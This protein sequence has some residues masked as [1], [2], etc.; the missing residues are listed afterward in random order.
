VLQQQQQQQQRTHV[1]GSAGPQYCGPPPAESV[2]RV[3][4]VVSNKHTSGSPC[5]AMLLLLGSAACAMLTVWVHSKKASGRG[6]GHGRWSADTR[7]KRGASNG[8]Q[9]SVAAMAVSQGSAGCSQR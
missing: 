3:L 9:H 4:Q 1:S 8:T 2:S 5:L 6:A 7:V